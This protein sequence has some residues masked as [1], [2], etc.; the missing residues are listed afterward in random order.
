MRNQ[1]RLILDR[2]GI[3]NRGLDTEF[4]QIRA[5]RIPAIRAGDAEM[6]DGIGIPFNQFQK[7]DVVKSVGVNRSQVAPV[8]VPGVEVRQKCPEVTGLDF[9]EA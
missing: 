5:D 6:V 2:D 7:A 3:V 1:S 8:P 4:R 9:I